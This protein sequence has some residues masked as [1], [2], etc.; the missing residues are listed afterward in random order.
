MIRL[1][2]NVNKVATLRNSRGGAVPSVLDAVR[3]CVD[4]GRAWHHRASARRPAAHHARRRPRRSPRRWRRCRG[5]SS[6]TS[7]AIRAPSCSSSCRRCGPTSARSCRSCPARS[8]ARQAGC[9]H[10][11]RTA[12][13]RRGLKSARHPR[14]PVRR[15]GRR[16][17]PAG[18]VGRRRPRRALHRAVRAGVRARPRGRGE[19]VPRLRAAA[20]LAHAAGLGVN[21]GHDL[22]LEN[23][24][25]PDAAASRRGLDRPR[26]HFPRGVRRARSRGARISRCPGGARPTG[27]HGVASLLRCAIVRSWYDRVFRMKSDG[28]AFGIAGILF[29]L[30]AGW[31]IGSQ[32]KPHAGSR[33]PRRRR[34]RPHRRRHRRPR[35]RRGQGDSLQERGRPRAE[36]RRPARAARQPVLRRGAIRRRDQ[37]V[38]GGAEA[39]RRTTSG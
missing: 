16:S 36:E 31:I 2:V 15:S 35:P 10:R 25:L 26:H 13:R 14:Q 34:R 3:V 11:L 39:R 21:A 12:G 19:V 29:G 32:P 33:S 30:I 18:R 24:A 23:L 17:R 1:S 9:R 7:K 27:S 4:G 37:V 20:E 28:V 22:D 8:R 5:A 6:S 38:R